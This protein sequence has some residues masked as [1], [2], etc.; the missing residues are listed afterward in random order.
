[1]L[2][3]ACAPA[4]A[5]AAQKSSGEAEILWDHAGV[6]HIYAKSDTVGFKAFGWTHMASHGDRILELYARAR[7]RS[8]EYWGEQYVETDE[9]TRRLGFPRLAEQWLVWLPPEQRAKLEAFVAGMNAYARSHHERIAADKRVVLPVKASDVLAHFYQIVHGTY[10]GRATINKAKGLVQAEEREKLGSNAYAIAPS[11]SASGNAM[12]VINPHLSWSDLFTWLEVHLELP[13]QSIYGAA[14]IGIPFVALGFSEFGGWTHT[15]NEYDGADLYRLA[16]EGDGYVLDGAVRPF[17]SQTEMLKVRRADGSVESRALTIRRSVHGPVIAA[18]GEAA[19]ALRLTELEPFGV[20]QQYWDMAAARTLEQFEAAQRRLQMPFF[21][22][23]YANREG[24]IFY[25]H[26]GRLPDRR[27]GDHEF[28]RG[29]IPGDRSEFLWSATLGYDALPH[30]S[31]PPGGFIQ[32]ANDPPW[33]TTYPEVLHARDYPAF[34]ASRNPVVFRPQHSLRQVIEDESITFDELVAMKQSTRLEMADRFLPE[35]LQAASAA[36]DADV[37]QAAQVLSV[38][39]RRTDAES[40][41]ALLFMAWGKLLLA[42]GDKAY[43]QRWQPDQPYSTPRGLADPTRAVEL[44]RMAAIKTRETFGSLDAPYGKGY[45]IR[46]DGLDLPG[47]GGPQELGSYRVT[48]SGAVERDGT[49]TLV[50]GDS[51]AAVVEFGERVRARGALAYGASQPGMITSGQ[52]RQAFSKGELR[53]LWFYPQDV[54]ANA[55]RTERIR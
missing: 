52:Q 49:A 53:S 21:N 39:D 37:R 10:I 45:R 31:D 25:L 24:R 54:R 35:L 3:V 28:W 41:G 12:L 17:E 23:I 34:V 6:P 13:S 36:T 20:L 32:N 51:F 8:A 30:F 22:T 48:W 7:G 43:A 19:F 47:S 33:S 11:R 50:G 55:A 38:W 14:V 26:G 9:V 15:V 2:A 42:E 18:K 1:M 5:A 29:V 16:L 40:R 27:V 4:L 46:A 44:L